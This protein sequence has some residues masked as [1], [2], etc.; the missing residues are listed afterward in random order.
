MIYSR[1]IGTGSY[2][3]EKKLANRDL[4][5]M[6]DTSDEWIRERTGIE[7]RRIAGDNETTSDLAEYAARNA[8]NAAGI[9]GADIDMIV[10]GTC[11]LEDRFPSAS[12]RLQKRLRIKPGVPAFDLNAACSG[13]IYALSIADQYIRSG[14]IKTALIVGVEKMSSIVDW[15]NRET[16]VL[17]GDGAGAVV[18][19]ASQE[20]GILSTHIY[21]DGTYEDLLNTNSKGFVEMKGNEVFRVAVKTLGMLVDETLAANHF[22]QS[23]VD[24]LIPHQAN[25]RII[26]ATAKKLNMSMEQVILTVAEHGNTSAASIPLA[27]DAGIKDGRIKRNQVLLMEAF[28]AGFTWGSAL[29]KY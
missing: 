2:L 22:K 13:F 23:Q 4:E 25:M 12:V 29:I 5:K 9:S 27:L 3:P 24:W 8:L 17:F 16:C 11:T 7:E 6:V 20:P 28:G 15:T 26:T 21:A 14:A 1:I 18:L 19:K 10:V